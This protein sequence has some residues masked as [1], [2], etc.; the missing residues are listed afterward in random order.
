MKNPRRCE[1]CGKIIDTITNTTICPNCSHCQHTSAMKPVPSN[2]IYIDNPDTSFWNAYA[3]Y[4][5]VPLAHDIAEIE[6]SKE[7]WERYRSIV[8]AQTQTFGG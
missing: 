7:G 8:N 3:R 1:V 4:V 5:L 6:N 2:G